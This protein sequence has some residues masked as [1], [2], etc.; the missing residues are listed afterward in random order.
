MIPSILTDVKPL[1][2]GS[3]FGAGTCGLAGFALGGPGGALIGAKTGWSLGAQ[4]GVY[5]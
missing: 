5:F 4:T 3:L 1:A 2:F